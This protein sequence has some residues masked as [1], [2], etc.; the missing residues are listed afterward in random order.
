[1]HYQ[2]VQHQRSGLSTSSLTVMLLYLLLV[3]AGISHYVGNRSNS[4]GNIE[5]GRSHPSRNLAAGIPTDSV[6]SAF[7]AAGD[8]TSGQGGSSDAPGNS[9]R[10]WHSKCAY[11]SMPGTWVDSAEPGH[12]WQLL[13][14]YCQLKNWLAEYKAVI[15]SSS[16]SSSD[17]SSSS[18]SSS[19]P[20]AAVGEDASAHDPAVQAAAAAASS[21]S[22]WSK[23]T[24]GHASKITRP[25]NS[26][27][28]STSASNITDMGSEQQLPQVRILLLSDSVDRYIVQHA[29][30]Y[31]GGAKETITMSH[32]P[33]QTPVVPAQDVSGDAQQHAT[34]AAFA[35][36][37]TSSSSSSSSS[38]A[39][40]LNKTAYAF[41][42]C[43]AGRLLKLASSY[44]PGVHPNGP[45]HRD[46][47]QNYRWE[48]AAA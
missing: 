12:R 28:K 15:H 30:N 41:H 7:T 46:L 5:S 4:Q 22:F 16:S 35:A 42:V 21:E 27:S 33:H 19:T 18:S 34:D 14:T 38:G 13:V 48:K 47:S 2:H 43:Q 25:F 44:F 40:S 36:V 26:S 6:P 39:S 31:L 29:C 45:F 32:L 3:S 23:M 24:F 10:S 37:G 11:G 17:D 9:S 1:M 8:V 20:A